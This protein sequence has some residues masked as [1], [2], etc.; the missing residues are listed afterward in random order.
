M[1][2]HDIKNQLMALEGYLELIQ[3]SMNDPA[4]VSGFL[5]KE[6]KIAGTIEHQ[7]NFTKDYEDMGVQAP[8]WQNVPDKNPDGV[9]G[10]PAWGYPHRC[11]TE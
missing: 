8:E 5:E 3:D 4:L 9:R 2:R 1:T 11:E 6:R 7:I 10:T